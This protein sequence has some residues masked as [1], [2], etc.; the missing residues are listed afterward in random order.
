[1]AR[2]TLSWPGA[3]LIPTDEVVLGPAGNG[4]TPDTETN[5]RMAGLAGFLSAGST[6]RSLALLKFGT[7]AMFARL[8]DSSSL[9]TFPGMVIT[10][11]FSPLSGGDL[12]IRRSW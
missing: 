4:I 5:L 10:R 8:A 11:L 7:P 6:Q 12:S 9:P 2:L 3:K 1:M